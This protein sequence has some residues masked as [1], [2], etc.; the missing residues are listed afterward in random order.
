MKMTWRC[1]LNLQV[2]SLELARLPH[3]SGEKFIP[4][5]V[6][7]HQIGWSEKMDWRLF[8]FIMVAEIIIWID[9]PSA[10]NM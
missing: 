1:Y 4:C 3:M 7:I 6:Y 8:Y 2:S 10:L 5:I 9:E